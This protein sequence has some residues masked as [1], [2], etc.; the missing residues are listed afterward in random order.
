MPATL[1][2]YTRKVRARPGTLHPQRI[3]IKTLL[4]IL[5]TSE[6]WKPESSYLPGSGVE[7]LNRMIKHALKSV[8]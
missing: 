2:F 7:P 5:P 8:R 1:T 6:G 3:S 4:L